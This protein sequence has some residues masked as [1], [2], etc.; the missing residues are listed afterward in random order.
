M[1]CWSIGVLA[2]APA[3][4]DAVVVVE[5]MAAAVVLPIMS[6]VAVML[7]AAGLAAVAVAVVTRMVSTIF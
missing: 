3:A 4:T 7:I 2:M 6:R 1:C 5:V